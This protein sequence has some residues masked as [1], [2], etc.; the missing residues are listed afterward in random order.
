VTLS[1]KLEEARRQRLLAAGRDPGPAR[2]RPEPTPV[3]APEQAA[4]FDPLVFEV[5]PVP[6]Q[7]VAAAAAN[8]FEL[9]EAPDVICPNCRRPGR[10]DLVDLVGQTRHCSCEFCGSMWQVREDIA[11]GLA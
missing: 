1:D 2:R 8:T 9:S 7:L 6:G 5:R 4:L 11:A 10:L 3:A